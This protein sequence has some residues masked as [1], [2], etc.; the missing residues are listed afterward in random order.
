MVKTVST[1]E[2]RASLGDV[3]NRVYYTKE[4]VIVQ[5]NGKVIAV[6]IS[7]EAFQRLQEED[8]R[9][10]ALIEQVGELND[11]KDPDTVLADVTAEV[12][13]VRREHHAG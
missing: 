8:A 12:E 5:K 6:I 10:W 4:P 3:L 13:A 11:D 2:A 7:P 9:D 1:A